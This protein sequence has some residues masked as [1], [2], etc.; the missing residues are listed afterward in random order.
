MEN[1]STLALEMVCGTSP[2]RKTCINTFNSSSSFSIVSNRFLELDSDFALSQDAANRDLITFSKLTR[3][4][5]FDLASDRSISID[6]MLVV[7]SLRK[8][9]V[10]ICNSYTINI[11]I[12][13]TN[14]N[15][16]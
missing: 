10:D 16:T 5:P 8:C 9:S 7:P 4:L 6:K 13:L 1:A 3:T 2:L 12:F 15:P 14:V 11:V